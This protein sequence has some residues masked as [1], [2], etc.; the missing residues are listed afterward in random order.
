MCFSPSEDI[1]LPTT[2]VTA[3]YYG[4]MEISINSQQLD[5]DEAL[6]KHNSIKSHSCPPITTVVD[7]LEV[8]HMY[9]K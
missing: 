5:F 1:P 2:P 6:S 3:F 7:D 4:C 8:A 9:R